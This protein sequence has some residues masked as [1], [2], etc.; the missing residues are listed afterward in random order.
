VVTPPATQ[1]AVIVVLVA[2]IATQVAAIAAQVLA[3]ATQVVAVAAFLRVIN[4]L[5]NIRLS[6]ELLKQSE[7]FGFFEREKAR[8]LLKRALHETTDSIVVLRGGGLHP[9]AV[10]ELNDARGLTQSASSRFLGRGRLTRQAIEAQE[11]ARSR[12]I[13][14]QP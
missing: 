7:G 6:V 8:Q 11:R 9:E 14:D 13:G 3:V 10:Q 4:A 2:P 12:L 5:E 1:V